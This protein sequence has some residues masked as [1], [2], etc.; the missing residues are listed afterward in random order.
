MTDSF[1]GIAP[2]DVPGFVA[3]QL[4]GAGLAV[5]LGKWLFAPPAEGEA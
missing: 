4:V 2:A 3:A 1:S 5:L